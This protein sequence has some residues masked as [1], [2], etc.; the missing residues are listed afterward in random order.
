MR[1]AEIDGETRETNR[2]L[3]EKNSLIN[4][5]SSSPVMQRTSNNG[6]HL[7]GTSRRLNGMLFPYGRRMALD[8]RTYIIKSVISDRIND[9]IPFTE[10]VRLPQQ[11]GEL[12]KYNYMAKMISRWRKLSREPAGSLHA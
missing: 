6:V 1:Q 5:C 3:E 10:P 9:I 11:T 12:H 8:Q 7:A 2:S 4:S